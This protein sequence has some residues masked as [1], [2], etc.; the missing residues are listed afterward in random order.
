MDWR[1]KVGLIFLPVILYGLMMIGRTFPV[2]E[3]V[4]AGSSYREMLKEFGI[5]GAM[6]VTALI[7]RE[8]LGNVFG[9]QLV[10]N[11][12][13]F[14]G[15]P[16]QLAVV[17][18][19]VGAFALYAPSLGRP[20]F[21]FLLLVMIPLATTEIGTDGWITSLMEP[22]MKSL[23]LHAAWVLVYTSFIMMVLR[24]FAGPIVHKLSPLGLLAV[25]S[26]IAAVGLYFLSTAA[27]V[28]ILVAATFYGFGK[29]FFWP[30]MLGVVSEQFPKGGALTLNATGGVGMLGV[31]VLGFPF[32]GLLQENAVTSRLE[33][34]Q[35]ALYSQV[36][37]EEQGVLGTYKAVN[38]M[39]LE[40]L[41]ETQREI[42]AGIASGANQRAL[43][44]MAIF[45]C[46]MLVCYLILIAY[47]RAKGGY[48]A[49]VLAGHAAEDEKF[50]GGVE[51]PGEG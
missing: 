35:P 26:I 50:T 37:T 39:K 4:A 49:E 43:A 15:W 32:I 20:M 47:F 7:V 36:V 5:I 17:A 10:Q 14:G 33:K 3:R 48:K 13:W 25:S 40:E 22:Q 2:H 45:P 46:I 16:L 27:G 38:P 6:I 28:A 9:V 41:P 23:G 42:V 21:I 19:A 34:E 12:G 44:T 51:G 31:G 11:L 24:F 18:V 8:V 30:T 29:T 1:F